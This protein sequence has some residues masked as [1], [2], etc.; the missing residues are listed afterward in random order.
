M[1]LDAYEQVFDSYTLKLARQGGSRMSDAPASPDAALP[2]GLAEPAFDP[3]S[4][5][6]LKERYFARKADGSPETPKEFLW[7]VASAIAEPER[8]YATANGR[9]PDAVAD[10]PA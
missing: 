1:S 10:E 2:R 4:M 8:P 3:N 7:R 6:V 9:D 5:R